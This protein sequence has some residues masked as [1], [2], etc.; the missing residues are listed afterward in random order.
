MK[1][2]KADQESL[3]QKFSVR[4]LAQDTG[5]TESQVALFTHKIKH[6]TDHLRIH[7]KD[8]SSRLGLTKLVGQRKRLLSYL[9]R[10]DLARYRAAIASL[11]LRK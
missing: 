9:K 8:K 10:K 3:F 4:K 5:S 1:L 2:T 11:G 6:L 7:K